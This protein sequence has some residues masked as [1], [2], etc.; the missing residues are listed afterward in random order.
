MA[1]GAQGDHAA[2]IASV[3]HL[4]GSARGAGHLSAW[5]EV[6]VAPRDAAVGDADQLVALA[7]P[8]PFGAVGRHYRDFSATTDDEVRTLLGS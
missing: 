8:W 6:P 4:I 7:R 5:T 1:D 3:L 2:V